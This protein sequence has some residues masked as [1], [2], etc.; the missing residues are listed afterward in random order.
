[1]AWR[2][3]GLLI[4]FLG[5]SMS[6]YADEINIPFSVKNECFKEIMLSKGYDLA[7]TDESWGESGFKEGT[8]KVI[9]YKQASIDDLNVIKDC[10]FDCAR[11]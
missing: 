6:T 10:A 7:G 11:T 5:L 8:F 9:S 1:M 4:T 3:L 2:V